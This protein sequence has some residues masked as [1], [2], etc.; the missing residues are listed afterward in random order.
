MPTREAKNER[1]EIQVTPDEKRLLMKA[2]ASRGM[3]V[4][5]FVMSVV[6]PRAREVIAENERFSVD[7][8]QLAQVLELLEHPPEPTEELV[9]AMRA[10]RQR[11]R[12]G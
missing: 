12:H 3:D 11:R 6:L 10:A 8:E 7:A 2:A 1:I 9:A 4:S 5:A